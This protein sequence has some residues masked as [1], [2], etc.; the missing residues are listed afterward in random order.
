MGHGGSTGRNYASEQRDAY[1]REQRAK[2]RAEEKKLDAERDAWIKSHKL[3]PEEK[4]WWHVGWWPL[5]AW[6]KQRKAWEEELMKRRLRGRVAANGVDIGE[7]V[8]MRSHQD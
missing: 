2:R 5:Y 6:W 7:A 1:R 4:K 8:L 3:R